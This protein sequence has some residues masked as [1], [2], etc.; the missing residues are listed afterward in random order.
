MVKGPTSFYDIK[1]LSTLKPV[2]LF[3]RDHLYEVVH[4]SGCSSFI[5]MFRV[6]LICVLR[7]HVKDI[8]IGKKIKFNKVIFKFF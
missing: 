5:N 3:T 6:M 1:H 2:F 7:A 4:V 8:I